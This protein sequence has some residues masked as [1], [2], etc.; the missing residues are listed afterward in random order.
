MPHLKDFLKL[1]N[2]LDTHN[3]SNYH[4]NFEFHGLAIVQR[5]RMLTTLT[6]LQGS[7]PNIHMVAHNHL[8]L[9]FGGI[10]YLLTTGYYM[11][12]V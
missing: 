4:A 3:S 2:A 10:C 1:L 9:Q 7:S 8:Q 11:N 5:L 6:E 12:I